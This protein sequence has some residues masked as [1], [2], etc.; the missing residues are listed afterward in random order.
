MRWKWLQAALARCR[1]RASAACHS[2]SSCLGTWGEH[3][4]NKIITKTI[5]WK[6]N[7]Y[8]AISWTLYME[9]RHR[10]PSISDAVMGCYKAVPGHYEAVLWAVQD[11]TCIVLFLEPYSPTGW[12]YSEVKRGNMNDLYIFK[13]LFVQNHLLNQCLSL[14]LGPPFL[15]LC[16]SV[17]FSLVIVQVFLQLL[18]PC[19]SSI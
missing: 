16:L 15:Q 12:L 9:M 19:Q 1:Q 8:A 10:K 18:N 17:Y 3:R 5:L 6:E 2:L 14:F 7:L 4:E 13:I 11:A